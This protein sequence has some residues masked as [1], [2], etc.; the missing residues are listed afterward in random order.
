M[1]V[2]EVLNRIDKCHAEPPQRTA[3]EI[4]RTPGRLVSPSLLAGLIP[5]M[6]Q[7][8]R[9]IVTAMPLH[10]HKLGRNIVK[11]LLFTE[12]PCIF[13]IKWLPHIQTVQPHLMRIDLFVPEPSFR[14]PGMRTELVT[15]QGSC[16]IVFLFSGYLIQQ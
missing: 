6:I 9:L 13:S 1:V 2:R 11:N 14:R 8:P 15:Q 7:Q 10:Q 3:P 5:T 12:E 16:L 4:W